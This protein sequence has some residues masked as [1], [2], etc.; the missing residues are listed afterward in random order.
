MAPAGD[1]GALRVGPKSVGPA[2]RIYPAVRQP[3]TAVLGRVDRA[4]SAGGPSV[5]GRL[6]YPRR[7]RHPHGK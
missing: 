4:R 5:G 7:H 3:R 6:G 1:Q 2:E